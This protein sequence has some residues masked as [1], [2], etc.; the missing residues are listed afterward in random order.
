MQKSTTNHFIKRFQRHVSNYCNMMHVY[1]L[2]III[3]NIIRCSTQS[4]HGVIVYPPSKSYLIYHYIR[5]RW[6]QENDGSL[7]DARVNVLENCR[8]VVV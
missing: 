5:W 8:R 4:T 7:I 2:I 3:Y 1:G 6:E